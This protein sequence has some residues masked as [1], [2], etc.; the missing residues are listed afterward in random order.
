MNKHSKQTKRFKT[1]PVA[2]VF[3][4]AL[5]LSGAYVIT[6]GNIAQATISAD[7]SVTAIGVGQNASTSQL[8]S[9]VSDKFAEDSSSTNVSS[10]A[11]SSTRTTYSVQS[12]GPTDVGSLEAGITMQDGG[13]VITQDEG[14]QT[15]AASAYSLACNTGYDATASG[16]KLTEY[17]MTV[18][19]PV[20]KSYLLGRTV[21][22]YYNG[23]TV[24]AKVTDTGGFESMGRDLD[25]AGGVWRALGAT[26][27]DNWGVRTVSYRFL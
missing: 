20:S 1:I 16:I 7:E 2:L 4:L 24:T 14:W 5:V 17:S 23:V 27:T 9:E 12:I 25:L 26:N 6:H 18:A 10:L 15:G 19:V 3:M 8:S 13:V 11:T 21:E 22:I